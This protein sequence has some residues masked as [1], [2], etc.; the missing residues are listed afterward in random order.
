MKNVCPHKKESLRATSSNECG[1]KERK[2]FFDDLK[3]AFQPN[4]FI[5]SPSIAAI[6][7]YRISNR[8]RCNMT[9]KIYFDCHGVLYMY[10]MEEK[11]KR[12][13]MIYYWLSFVS[14]PQNWNDSH[15]KIAK[16]VNVSH[17]YDFKDLFWFNWIH[18]IPTDFGTLETLL[19]C[20]HVN[21]SMEKH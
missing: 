7:Q 12:N 5:F 1:K 16:P 20:S 4:I 2:K 19:L 18:G 13:K 17:H 9:C 6:W 8:L 3:Y 11:K 10:P 14:F 15:N 21:W